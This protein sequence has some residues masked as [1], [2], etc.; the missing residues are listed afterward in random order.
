MA[1]EAA[2]EAVRGLGRRKGRNSPR[3]A[4][5]G[6]LLVAGKEGPFI[7]HHLPTLWPPRAGSGQ[8]G[9]KKEERYKVTI[10]R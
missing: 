8:V 1:G 2:R 4:E 7:C 10:L 3:Q 9:G 5:F 6:P